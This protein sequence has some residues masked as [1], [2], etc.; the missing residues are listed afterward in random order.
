MVQSSILLRSGWTC[1]YSIL[2]YRTW[3]NINSGLGVS[4][5]SLLLLCILSLSSPDYLC[6]IVACLSYREKGCKKQILGWGKRWRLVWPRCLWWYWLKIGSKLR[7]FRWRGRWYM[8]GSLRRRRGRRSGIG[9]GGF[10]RISS[11][12]VLGCRRVRFIGASKIWRE[13]Y[14]NKCPH[15]VP[16]QPKKYSNPNQTTPHT[17]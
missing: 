15:Y 11:C 10:L 7:I 5:P 9:R 3:D 17:L 12:W 4:L 14:R 1:R 13:S 16:C 2:L 8:R 6:W